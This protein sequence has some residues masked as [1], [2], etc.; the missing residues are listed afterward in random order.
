MN[1]QK[2]WPMPVITGAASY[3]ENPL[4]QMGDVKVE[5]AD[6]LSIAIGCGSQR[7]LNLVLLG[8]LSR[9]LPFGED[10]WKEAISLCVPRKTLPV[11]LAAFEQGRMIGE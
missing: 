11:N 6:A 5:S 7:A 8:M 10:V 3:P 9:H 2:I 4:D 1:R